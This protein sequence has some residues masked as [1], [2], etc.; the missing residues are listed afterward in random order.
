[1]LR[2]D[3]VVLGSLFDFGVQ[4][5]LFSVKLSHCNSNDVLFLTS[6]DKYCTDETVAMCDVELC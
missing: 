4:A 2:V 5:F 6:L 1:M 3:I